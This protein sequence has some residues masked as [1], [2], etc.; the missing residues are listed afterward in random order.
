[1]SWMEE[2]HI[3]TT[4]V[5]RDE[6]VSELIDQRHAMQDPDESV[7][8]R[9]FLHAVVDTDLCV[10]LHW[11]EKRFTPKGSPVGLKLAAGLRIVCQVKHTV[12]KRVPLHSSSA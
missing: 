7:T 11:K 3:R 1:M 2:L 8:M 10:H 4:D 6:I 5:P 9:I 12:W